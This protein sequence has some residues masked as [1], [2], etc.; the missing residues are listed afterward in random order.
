MVER[1]W[2]DYHGNDFRP[3]YV[4][5]AA[6]IVSVHN[7]VAAF[8]GVC[9]QTPDFAYLAFPLIN[10]GMPHN[11]RDLAIDFMVDSAI[12]WTVSN[13][14]TILWYSG[15]GEKFLSR[16]RAKGWIAGETGCQHMFKVTG[17]IS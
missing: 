7:Q 16:L 11:I 15:N 17:E 3:G 10:P 9:P 1:W 12:I 4:P 5:K 8:F 13:A 14:M 2:R 6:F